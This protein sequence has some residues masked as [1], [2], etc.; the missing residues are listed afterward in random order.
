MLLASGMAGRPSHLG[1]RIELLLRRSREFTPK[2][3]VTR[4]VLGTA[5]LIAF[6]VAGAHAP[7]LL[8]FSQ[9]PYLGVS[10]EKFDGSAVTFVA[11]VTF[12]TPRTASLR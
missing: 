9:D 3:S 5:A 6:A 7:R 10:S 4:I 12:S 1:E 2:A 8:A 11:T